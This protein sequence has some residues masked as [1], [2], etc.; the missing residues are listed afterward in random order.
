MPAWSDDYALTG[1]SSKDL[2]STIVHAGTFSRLV[3]GPM[4]G[5]IGGEVLG[6][7]KYAP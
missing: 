2:K 1:L 3:G 6:S 4:Y 5:W 7:A